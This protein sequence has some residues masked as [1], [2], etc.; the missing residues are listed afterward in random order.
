MNYINETATFYNL[1]SRHF[2]YCVIYSITLSYSFGFYLLYKLRFL[3]SK[4][5]LLI[6]LPKGLHVVLRA[7][8]AEIYI[9][10]IIY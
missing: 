1:L 2:I 7:E 8:T 5:L 9:Y 4:H 6:E 3:L 10:I